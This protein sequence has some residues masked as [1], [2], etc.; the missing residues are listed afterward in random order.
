MIT[1]ERKLRNTNIRTLKE[2]GILPRYLDCCSNRGK[3]LDSKRRSIIPFNRV[4]F[5]YEDYSQ[6]KLRMS[7]IASEDKVI[8]DDLYNRLFQTAEEL[9]AEG[10]DL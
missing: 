1:P 4:Y 10:Y 3:E 6:D 7:K 2:V 9:R 5:R 8:P